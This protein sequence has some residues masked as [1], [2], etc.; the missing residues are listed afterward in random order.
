M[1]ML[2]GLE[3][4][5]G[6][7]EWIVWVAGLFQTQGP[8]CAKANESVAVPALMPTPRRPSLPLLK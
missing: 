5:V 7:R 6:V 3:G 2:E 4:C 8:A 1:G